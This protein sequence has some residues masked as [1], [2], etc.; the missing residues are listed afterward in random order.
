[1]SLPDFLSRIYLKLSNASRAFDQVCNLLKPLVSADDD[2]KVPTTKILTKW[3]PGVLLK[4]QKPPA[5]TN[6]IKQHDP[7][8]KA[9][10]DSPLPDAKPPILVANPSKNPTADTSQSSPI[11][12]AG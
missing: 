7:E 6:G 10:V 8:T 4:G 2:A 11:A 3:R 5:E 1:M 9:G 12:A